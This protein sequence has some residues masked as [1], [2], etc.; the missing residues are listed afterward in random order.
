MNLAYSSSG[1]TQ[2]NNS[3]GSS[4]PNPYFKKAFAWWTAVPP[5]AILADHFVWGHFMKSTHKQSLNSQKDVPS[6]SP[7]SF[8][9][10]LER[11]FENDL[12]TFNSLEVFC[13]LVT[14]SYC[15]AGHHKKT[16][17]DNNTR[18]ELSISYTA[19]DSSPPLFP[20]TTYFNKCL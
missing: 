14:A 13:L 6:C 3:E 1:F 20:F 18:D 10:V 5:Q 7:Y 19:S 9:Q 15:T 11:Y 4:H 8:S 16:L 12:N 2:S 17:V